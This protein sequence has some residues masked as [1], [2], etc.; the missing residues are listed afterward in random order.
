M[1]F[2]V[3][4]SVSSINV[5]EHEHARLGGEPDAVAE[6]LYEQYLPRYAKAKQEWLRGYIRLE[7]GIPSADTFARVFQRL[8]VKEFMA[9]LSSW[10]ESLRARV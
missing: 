10:V 6:A 1:V 3:M 4:G 8:N 2:P 5:P 7:N 9:C